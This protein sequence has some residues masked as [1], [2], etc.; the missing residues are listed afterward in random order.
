MGVQTATVPVVVKTPGGTSPAFNITLTRNAPAIYTKDQSGTGAAL[1]FDP[2]FNAVTSVATT[3]IVLYATGLGPTSPVAIT[4]QLGA[5]AEPLNRVQ[6]AVSV[7]IGQV[8]GTVLYAGLAPGL[9]GIYQINVTPQSGSL[10]NVLTAT[11]GN[12]SA[13]PLT[14]PVLAGTNVANV[15]GS[16]SALYPTS[17][18]TIGMSAFLTAAAVTAGFD[19][20]PGAKPFQVVA[21]SSLGGG[22]SATISINPAQNTWQ[23]SYTVPTAAT[24]QGD[25]SKAG[26]TVTDFAN[27][28]LPFPGNILP[29]SRLDPAALKACNSL[30]L[31]NATGGTVPNGLWTASGTIP[32]GGHFSTSGIPLLSGAAGFGGF[33]NIVHN[34][35]ATL[36]DAFNLYVDGVL[37]NSALTSFKE[38]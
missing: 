37:V 2:Y 24:C 7:S 8:A 23:A 12:Y 25:F 5:G 16:I 17:G 18:G 32:A 35:G 29:G 31:P 6:D 15:S 19:I 34:S 10:G 26:F 33:I 3:P 4:G 38:Y 36:F 27:N 30:P 14:L 9:Q 22:V 1:V 28:N 20:L 21:Q 11:A 13:Q